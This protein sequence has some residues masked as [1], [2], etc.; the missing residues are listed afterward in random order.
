L[1]RAQCGIPAEYRP[2][3]DGALVTFRCDFPKT[4]LFLF[5]RAISRLERLALPSV[6]LREL[7]DD[8]QRDLVERF[9]LTEGYT[10]PSFWY[11]APDVIRTVCRH[12]LILQLTLALYKEQGHLPTRIEALFGTWLDR[13]L[14]S[15]LPLARRTDLRKLLTS[16]ANASVDGPLTEATAVELV[17]SEGFSDDLLQSLLDARSSTFH[18]R[19]VVPVD[20]PARALALAPQRVRF[21]AS[22]GGPPAA[23]MGAKR[24]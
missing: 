6:E 22:V 4:Q 7:N 18:G 21:G 8:E 20:H 1:S 10:G 11:R 16:F 2:D 14:P 19:W 17:C 13:L 15:S 9:S 3:V 23:A 5:T 24:T 12:P